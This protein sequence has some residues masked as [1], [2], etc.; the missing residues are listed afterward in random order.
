MDLLITIALGASLGVLAPYVTRSIV[1]RI[2]HV[3]LLCAAIWYVIDAFDPLP[4]AAFAAAAIG[5]SATLTCVLERRG[6]LRPT[7]GSSPTDAAQ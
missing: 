6:T 7:D 5:T 4:G 2:A 3:V 1:P